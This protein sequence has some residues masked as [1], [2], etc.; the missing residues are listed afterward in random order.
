MNSSEVAKLHAT[1]T[2]DLILLDMHMPGLDGIGVM[3]DLHEIEKDGYLPV[4]AIT[5]DARFKLSAL[6]AGAR[7]FIT[8]PFEI[9]EL[10][11]RIRNTLE[12]R[13][14]YKEVARQS[15]LQELLALHDPLTGL[16]NRRLLGDR[17]ETAMQYARRNKQMLAAMY[18]DLDGFKQINDVHG[19]G[20]GDYVLMQIAERLRSATREVDTVARIGGDEFILILPEIDCRDD[21]IRPAST[22]LRSIS[23]PI[24]IEG[25][26]LNV[27]GSIG[28][29]FY[30]DNAETAENLISGAD[31]ALY[32][33]KRLGKNC[34]Q[35]A[36]S[37]NSEMPGSNAD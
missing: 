2:Y 4:L 22:I 16:P 5:A 18:L 23:S 26:V 29:A 10:D 21:L 17:I 37:D 11:V 9:A 7:D 13:L 30:P 34:F 27:T 3:K 31:A 24:S 12:V 33:A 36:D 35:F 32:Q 28:I 25:L 8:K 20:C 6:E 1:N 19:H 14:L 15:R